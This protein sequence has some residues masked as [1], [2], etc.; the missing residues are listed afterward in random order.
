MVE[1]PSFEPDFITSPELEEGIINGRIATF[2]ITEEFLPYYEKAASMTNF[3]VRV[4]A[5][6]GEH[7]IT[8]KIK[9]INRRLR[10]NGQNETPTITS[11]KSQ[12]PVR[13]GSVAISLKKPEGVTNDIAFHTARQRIQPIE[14]KKVPI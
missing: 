14:P 9:P 11:V 12:R 3:E 6:P 8:E 2:T 13:P 1:K 5:K 4:I 7:Y 10:T